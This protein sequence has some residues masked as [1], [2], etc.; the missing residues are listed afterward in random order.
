MGVE[1]SAASLE[2]K[3]FFSNLVD[4]NEDVAEVV[5]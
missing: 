5:E 4:L 2:Y 3:L 1:L